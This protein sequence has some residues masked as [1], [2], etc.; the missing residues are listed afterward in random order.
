MTTQPQSVLIVDDSKDFCDSLFDCLDEMDVDVN[1]THDPQTALYLAQSRDYDIALVDLN[2]PGRDGLALF[3]EMRR[4]HPRM[5]GVL[6]TGFGE[7]RTELDAE[8]VGFSAVLHKPIDF[9]QVIEM[10]VPSSE[11]F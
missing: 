4:L 3:R 10:V 7:D 1:A 11:S 8:A 9:A 6:M 2:M 5:R